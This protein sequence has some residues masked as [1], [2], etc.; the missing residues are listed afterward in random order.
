MASSPVMI[1][2]WDVRR[3]VAFVMLD[4]TILHNLR[5]TREVRLKTP[6]GMA[7]RVKLRA[8]FYLRLDCNTFTVTLSQ[9]TNEQ[10]AAQVLSKFPQAQTLAQSV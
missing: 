1:M 3:Y 9:D 4:D 5:L 6:E 7:T 10:E 8:E 2:T